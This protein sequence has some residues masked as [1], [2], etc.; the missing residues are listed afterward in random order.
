M[1]MLPHESGS[2]I[3]NSDIHDAF[4]LSYSSYF[5]MRRSLMQL[6]PP[7]WQHEFVL[8]TERFFEEFPLGDAQFTVQMRNGQGHFIKDRL[9]NYRYPDSGEVM[10]ARGMPEEEVDAARFDAWRRQP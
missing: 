10:R 7:D 9:S 2:E 5:V 3:C 8:L 1:S 4:G 6:M